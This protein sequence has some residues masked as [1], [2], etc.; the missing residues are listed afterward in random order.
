[1]VRLTGRIRNTGAEEAVDVYVVATLYDRLGRV[2]G[3]RRV[4]LDPGTVAQGGEA[5]FTVEIVPAG[6]VVTYT[7][8]AQG[9][10]VSAAPADG[11]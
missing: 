11:G 7:I 4:T 8:Q 2:V 10:R 6:P 5:G 3:M 9:R 1:M